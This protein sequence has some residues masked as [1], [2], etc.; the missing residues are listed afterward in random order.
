V[1]SAGFSVQQER[2]S[3]TTEDEEKEEKENQTTIGLT[4]DARR[5]LPLGAICPA[6]AAANQ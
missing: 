5:V 1:L 3:L 4:P 6:S 2:L